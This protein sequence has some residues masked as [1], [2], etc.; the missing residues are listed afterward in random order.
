MQ[1][2]KMIKSDG[3]IKLFA[4][5]G[6]IATISLF[7]I[8]PFVQLSQPKISHEIFVNQSIV[9][10]EIMIAKQSTDELLKSKKSLQSL[11][12][13]HTLKLADYQLDPEKFDNKD[14]LKDKSKDLRDK[15][16]KGR[17]AK[18]EK[19]IEKF[20]KLIEKIN[21]KLFRNGN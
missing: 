10:I 8:F 7:I 3:T 9:E 12:E 21:Q 16:I 13:E 4:I 17:I 2:T 6:L 18:L 20:K 19:E 15:I 5:F 14:K 11:I 1:N